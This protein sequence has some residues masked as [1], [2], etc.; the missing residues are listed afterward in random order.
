MSGYSTRSG[1]RYL[2]RSDEQRRLFSYHRR[3]PIA[4]CPNGCDELL[5]VYECELGIYL[6]CAECLWMSEPR[7]VEDAKRMAG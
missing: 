5:S 4:E 2:W 3:M 6:G 1:E 7:R